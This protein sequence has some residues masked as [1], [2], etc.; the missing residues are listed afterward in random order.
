[1]LLTIKEILSPTEVKE[2]LAEL[3]NTEFIDG[4]QTAGIANQDI[5]NNVELPDARL[6]IR[7]SKKILEKMQANPVFQFGIRPQQVAPFLFSRYHEGM[8]YGDHMD[9]PIMHSTQGPMRVDLS[10]TLFLNDPDEYEGGE[11]VLSP[12]NQTQLVK[13]HAGDMIVYPSVHIHRVN[14]VLS[15]VRKV[16]VSWMQ[17]MVRDPQHREILWDLMVVANFLRSQK[18]PDEAAMQRMRL[19]T[20]KSQFN[21]ARMWM[22]P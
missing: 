1:M 11:L 9:D 16:A 19:L 22:T 12:D 8:S 17:S 20:E 3:E 10:M 4:K 14:P 21:L 13:L 6:S 7:L 18:N 15:G 2:L 5:K